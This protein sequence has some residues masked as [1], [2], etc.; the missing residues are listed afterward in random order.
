MPFIR[1]KSSEKTDPQHEFH[2]STIEY[3]ANKDRYTRVEKG[4][5]DESRP[6]LYVEPVKRPETPR[7]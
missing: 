3:E 1:V 5:S 2:V 6:P 7:K 4:E